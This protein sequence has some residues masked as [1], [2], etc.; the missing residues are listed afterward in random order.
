M[1][2]MPGESVDSTLPRQ[3]THREFKVVDPG[4]LCFLW[5]QVYFILFTIMPQ[6]ALYIVLNC[7]K[8]NNVLN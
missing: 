1:S 6:F 3:C 8:K 4:L 7:S 5:T 2:A